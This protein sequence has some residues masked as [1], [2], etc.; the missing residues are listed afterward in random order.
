MTL[1]VS[2]HRPRRRCGMLYTY[3]VL[4]VYCVS[5]FCHKSLFLP[6]VTWG[7]KPRTVAARARA[8]TDQ[9]PR[10]RSRFM[11]FGRA[12]TSEPSTKTLMT[13]ITCEQHTRTVRSRVSRARKTRT[14]QPWLDVIVDACTPSDRGS[15]ERERRRGRT[16]VRSAPIHLAR[17]PA[18]RADEACARAERPAYTGTPLVRVGVG[19]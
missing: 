8:Q 2:P 18:A 4:V 3:F 11:N 16:R 15:S 14:S 17:R 7:N 12:I 5:D 6:P 19:Q 13:C 10:R 9:L 1:R